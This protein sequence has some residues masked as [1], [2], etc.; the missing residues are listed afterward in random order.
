[1][2]A[3]IA[4]V[5][6]GIGGLSL[7]LSLQRQGFTITIFERSP[8]IRAVGAGMTLWPNAT[9]ILQEL[10]ILQEILPGSLPLQK[11]EV[12][13]RSGRVLMT[14]PTEEFPTPA[15]AIHRADLHG[16]LMARITAP[17]RLNRQCTG[18]SETVQGAFLHFDDKVEGPFDI[19]IGAD[20]L[21]ST[22]R[23]YVQGPVV[24]QDRGYVV[25]R[26]LARGLDSILP[27]GTFT[28]SWGEG[29]RFGILPMG[30]DQVCW[31]ATANQKNL[32]AAGNREE[33]LSI[34]GD[35]HNPIPQILEHSAEEHIICS[36]ALDRRPQRGWSR[37][38]VVLLGDSVHPTSPNLGQGGCM[39]IE[40]AAVLARLMRASFSPQD[41]FASFEKLRFARTAGVT[42]RAG[43]IGDL[44]QWQHPLITPLRNLAC[45]MIPGYSFTLSSRRLH[46]YMVDPEG[47]PA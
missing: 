16:A 10:G 38:R 2:S 32:S 9:R 29:H 42:R 26:G 27:R 11:L 13:H 34:F 30:R 33:I 47:P 7:A 35:W 39:A 36:D 25:W 43:W 4:I 41:V 17:V 20:G 24:L 28:E 12:K 45:R 21:R 15:I 8:Q 3:K 46:T 37:G 1:M 31:Y 6:A 22:V 14:I 40:D 44:G 18:V 23:E 5:G 19:V